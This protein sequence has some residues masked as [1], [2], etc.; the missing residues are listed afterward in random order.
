MSASDPNPGSSGEGAATLPAGLAAAFPVFARA[1]AC[2]FG[3]WEFAGVC[4]PRG[5]GGSLGTRSLRPGGSVGA[6]APDDPGAGELAAGAP[7]A[8]AGG[9]ELPWVGGPPA[10]AGGEVPAGGGVVAGDVGPDGPVGPVEEAQAALSDEAAVAPA[11]Q[12]HAIA[13]RRR[14]TCS[15]RL[16]VDKQDRR[17]AKAPS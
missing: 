1:C 14:S 12:T 17:R 15:W 6:S 8:A 2:A 3:L 7:G 9:G 13:P 11:T 10:V 16:G 4:F 5:A